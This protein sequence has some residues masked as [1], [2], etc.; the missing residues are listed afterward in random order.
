MLNQ[1]RSYSNPGREANCGDQTK[2]PD[3]IG[4]RGDSSDDE[5]RSAQK[6]QVSEQ[7]GPYF[8]FRR[9]RLWHKSGRIMQTSYV[10]CDQKIIA[11]AACEV[12]P[13]RFIPREFCALVEELRWSLFF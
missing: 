2:D 9:G 4:L 1:E 5:N 13:F 10:R 3:T 6:Q 7:K 11:C 12:S 8:Q